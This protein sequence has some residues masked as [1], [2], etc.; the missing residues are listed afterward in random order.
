MKILFKSTKTGQL[1]TYG[2]MSV[3]YTR[4]TGHF[5]VHNEDLV[6][7]IAEKIRD[8]RY[9]EVEVSDAEAEAVAKL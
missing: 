1:Y 2:Q 6:C 8:G 4:A 3:N 9:V 7:W 5:H